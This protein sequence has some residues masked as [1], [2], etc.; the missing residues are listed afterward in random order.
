MPIISIGILYVHNLQLKKFI[1]LYDDLYWIYSISVKNKIGNHYFYISIHIFIRFIHITLLHSK[2]AILLKYI[3]FIYVMC[4]IY[5]FIGCYRMI[6]YFNK[7][8]T[9][10]FGTLAKKKIDSFNPKQTQPASD[11]RLNITKYLLLIYWKW[12]SI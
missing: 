3:L 2:R 4:L 6:E 8:Y 9:K 5:I 1:V 10:I 11:K 7:S 12:T